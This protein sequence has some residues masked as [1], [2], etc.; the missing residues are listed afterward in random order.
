MKCVIHVDHHDKE[1]FAAS[2]PSHSSTWNDRQFAVASNSGLKPVWSVSME[3]DPHSLRETPHQRENHKTL[4]F[5][6]AFPYFIY[7][8]MHILKAVRKH[9]S[10]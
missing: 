6:S 4:V 7:Y 3:Q 10:Q 5:L 1:S 2:Q 8:L 9:T